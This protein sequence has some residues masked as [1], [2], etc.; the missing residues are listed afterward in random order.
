[1]REVHFSRPAENDLMSISDYT[2]RKWGKIQAARYL[3]ELEA[4]CQT[5]ANDPALGQRCDDVR[6]GL[7]RLEH[8]KH[9]VKAFFL[10]DI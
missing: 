4:R 7:G 5:L 1:M 10:S 2:L 8:G 3:D 9:V 6:P